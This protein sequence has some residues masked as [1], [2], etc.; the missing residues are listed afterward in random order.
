MGKKPIAGLKIIEVPYDETSPHWKVFFSQR[1]GAKKV[2]IESYLTRPAGKRE[3][4]DYQLCGVYHKALVP[5]EITA[6]NCEDSQKAHEEQCGNISKETAAGLKEGKCVV[7]TGGG[8]SHAIGVAGG[9]QTALGKDKKIGFIWLDAHG[10]INT[11]EST[12][13][14]L[15]GGTPLAVCAG[16]CHGEAYDNWRLA[17]GLEIP[18]R[19][20]DIILSDARDLD[21]PEAEVLKTT[22]ITHLDTRAF[23][24]RQQWRRA[25]N[26]LAARVD[27]I[28]LHID[29]DILDGK[30]V[31]DH[32]TIEFG[33]PEI[34]TVMENI[35]AVMETDKVIAFSLVSVFFDN[36]KPG[37]EVS[38]LN[39]MRLLGTGLGNWRYCPDLG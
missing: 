35:K 12:Q 5:V 33:G 21:L 9:L 24:D 17:A 18:L 10:D 37:K 7:L 13:S 31:P 8:C 34:E 32:Y 22:E 4:D 15:L 36:G 6:I 23:N 1:E 28:Y 25:V 2:E 38:T 16:L 39:G 3:L 29:A 27:V 14:G 20:S 30:Y 26:D 19:Q 11:P